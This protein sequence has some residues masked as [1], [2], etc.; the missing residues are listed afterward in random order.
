MVFIEITEQLICVSIIEWIFRK[1]NQNCG[2]SRNSLVPGIPLLKFPY[3]IHFCGNLLG[4]N[5]AILGKF[6]TPKN[7]SEEGFPLFSCLQYCS[8]LS[9]STI[10]SWSSFCSHIAPLCS[11]GWSWGDV[12]ICCCAVNGT[13]IG[14]A[15]LYNSRN[16][17]SA[18]FTVVEIF[19]VHCLQW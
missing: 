10:S 3:I 14:S 18:L 13:N 5:H 6:Q 17:C 7:L 2:N 4:P 8:T 9:I 12:C 1:I 11:P 15:L 19:L 16:I